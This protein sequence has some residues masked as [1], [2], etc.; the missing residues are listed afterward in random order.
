MIR[1]TGF[2]QRLPEQSIDNV[3]LIGIGGL[4]SSGLA[5]AI[6]PNIQLLIQNEHVANTMTC[7]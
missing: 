7:R 2:Y 1:L 5:K 3:I 4:R 6:A